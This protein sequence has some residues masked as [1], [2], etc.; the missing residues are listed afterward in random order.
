[1]AATPSLSAEPNE[2]SPFLPAGVASN[3]Q[4][5]Y[6]DDIP[7][8]DRDQHPVCIRDESASLGISA[9]IKRQLYTSHFL[10]TWNS[11]VF[12]F[13]AI[14]FIAS[15]FPGTLFPSSLYALVRAASAICFAPVVGRYIDIGNRLAVVRF[16][17][18]KSDCLP[19]LTGTRLIS[20]Q[21]ICSGTAGGSGCI[22]FVF[23]VIGDRH[24]GYSVGSTDDISPIGL[25]GLCR[26]VMLDHE[27]CGGRARLG[28]IYSSQFIV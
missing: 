27:S 20:I 22:V 18:G 7:E 11:R 4:A 8:G 21:C 9:D 25:V 13:G 14:L 23:L 2:T 6:S 3:V 28:E 12:E 17:I 24:L 19:F 26:E 10:S 5:P 16:S 1:M 15:I